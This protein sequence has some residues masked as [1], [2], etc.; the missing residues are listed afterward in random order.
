[1][2]RVRCEEGK[3]LAR[4]AWAFWIPSCEVG[5]FSWY[6]MDIFVGVFVLRWFLYWIYRGAGR[7]V[8]S[9][10]R[11]NS[12]ALEGRGAGGRRSRAVMR[13][14]RLLDPGFNLV[15]YSGAGCT[16]RRDGRGEG[17][18]VSLKVIIF[19]FAYITVVRISLLSLQ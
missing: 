12:E 13:E 4:V 1:M 9:A 8:P 7:A 15:F 5:D 16:I 19:P 10:E 3:V 14:K 11:W 6:H 18:W 17:T 2:W